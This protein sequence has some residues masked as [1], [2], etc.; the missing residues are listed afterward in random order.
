MA[1]GDPDL[2]AQIIRANAH[3]VGQLLGSL[4]GQLDELI[5]LVDTEADEEELVRFLT[6]GVEGTRSIPGK[7]G[8]TPQGAGYRST[9]LHGS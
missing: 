3:V 7:H 9:A 5:G 4:R 8:G 2:Y 1:A 6:R